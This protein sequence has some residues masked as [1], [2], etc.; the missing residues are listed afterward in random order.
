MQSLNKVLASPATI[1]VK[2]GRSC[3]A[4]SVTPLGKRL[5]RTYR[6]VEASAARRI[7]REFSSF[8]RPGKRACA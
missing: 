4:A 6:R 2:G 8:A 7:T 3:G 1:A 5:I